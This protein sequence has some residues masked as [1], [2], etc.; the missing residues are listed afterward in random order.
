MSSTAPDF[1]LSETAF[2]WEGDGQWT[3]Y[4][5]KTYRMSDDSVYLGEKLSKK[6]GKEWKQLAVISTAVRRCLTDR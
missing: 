5:S 4:I 2:C 1:L 3:I 6:E